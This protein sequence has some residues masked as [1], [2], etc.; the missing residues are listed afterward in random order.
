MGR[1][2][3]FILA[4]T[5]LAMGL[6]WLVDRA[7]DYLTLFLAIIA[8][9]AAANVAQGG[10][11]GLIPDLVPVERRGRASA[12]KAVMELLPAAVVALVIARWLD[13][14]RLG[15]SLGVDIAV[16]GVTLAITMVGVRETV[17]R[18]RPPGRVLPLTL[19]VIEMLAGI[20]LGVVVSGSAGIALGSVAYAVTRLIG[21]ATEAAVASVMIAGS[22][23]IVGT[24]VIAVGAGVTIGTSGLGGFL[25]AIRGLVSRGT[26]GVPAW[27]VAFTGWV[28]NRLLFLVAAGSIAGFLLYFV[29]AVV[30][31]AFDQ[32]ASATGKLI[33]A[34]GL[35]TVVGALSSGFLSDRFGQ[36]RLVQAG[37]VIAAAGT[38]IVI[39]V[40]SFNMVLAAGAVLGFA[41]GTFYTANW[42][43][44]TELVPPKESAR[45]LGI[46]NLAGAG[47][48]I[49][50]T[51]LGGLIVDRLRVL[52]GND[53][54]RWLYGIYAMCF[55][56]SAFVLARTQVDRSGPPTEE[57]A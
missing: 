15:L 29:E 24:T 25:T 49:I 30:G 9:T 23:M 27:Q 10:L 36:R 35:S 3:P 48:G 37:G 55:A 41:G 39:S 53:S 16:M 8:Q 26:T 6:L 54:Y 47:A 28:T 19:R 4:G 56:L 40:P 44:G 45:F 7:S 11:Q 14:G 34:V 13:Q 5:V 42:A 2:R 20:A 22:T 43:M 38:L 57:A 21:T 51:G 33:F 50:G 17:L 52:V 31:I 32:A 12:V 1:R 18:D 46:A